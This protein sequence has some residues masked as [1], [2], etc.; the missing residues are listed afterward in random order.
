MKICAGE[1]ANFLNNAHVFLQILLW[2]RDARV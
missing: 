2:L 1:G